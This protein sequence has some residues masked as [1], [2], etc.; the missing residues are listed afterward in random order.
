MDLEELVV[1]F[2]PVL[3]LRTGYA[4]YVEALVRWST[5]TRGLLAPKDFIPS[6]ERSDL[7]VSIGDWVMRSACRQLLSWHE[8]GF[9]QLGLSVNLSP[10]QFLRADLVSS[11]KGILEDT[12]IAPWSLQLEI[13]ERAVR[14]MTDSAITLLD[15]VNRLG[16]SFALDNFGAGETCLDFLTRL[17]FRT[18][19][20]DRRVTRHVC[21]DGELQSL[22][23]AVVN[24]AHNLGLKVVASGVES[25]AEG[26][27]LKAKG[28][29]MVQGYA[30]CPPMPAERLSER[31][32]SM[33]PA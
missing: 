4:R 32:A 16:I 20:L 5:K 25:E 19:K 21:E 15:D 22:V 8:Q 33:V 7:I 17:S 11:V 29:D 18:I 1:H 31:L 26:A 24:L 12:A 10:A 30:Y 23:D 28:C 3:E 27:L 9:S 13:D 14:H 2:Q 6:A